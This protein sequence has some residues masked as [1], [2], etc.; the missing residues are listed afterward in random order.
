MSA[1]YL[2]F[3]G[4]R[5]QRDGTIG[6]GCLSQWWPAAFTIDSRE[7]ATAEHWMM[8]SKAVLF[9][10]T[11]IADQILAVSHPGAAKALGREVR[12]FNQAIWEDRRFA[13]VVAGSVAK[14]GQH[15]ALKRYLLGTGDL[16]LVEA[17]PVDR[18]WGIGLAASDPRAADPA[19]W[20]GLNLLGKALMEA[21]T[22]RRERS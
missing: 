10:D 8:W 13:I 3:W 22:I 20:R 17:S 21:R 11:E 12:R 9:G 19:H 6:V 1:R 18:I 14:F 7:Y 4:H 2:Y 15:E 5:P 16:V